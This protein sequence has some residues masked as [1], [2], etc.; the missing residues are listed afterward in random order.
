MVD[1]AVPTQVF[2]V[3]DN[4]SFRRVARA[5]VDAADGFDWVGDAA[6][7]AT[8]HDRVA[9]M[10]D[11]AEAER[12]VL[13]LVDVHLGS[14]DGIALAGELTSL[15][16][17]LPVALISTMDLDELPAEART[18]GAIGFLPKVAFGPTSLVALQDGA[19]AWA[20]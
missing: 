19:Y 7:A 13:V 3:D 12:R 15:H 6:D 14:A 16:P 4:D 5:V 9:S 11:G 20:P 18:S 2:I 17:G 10:V 8:A 1:V